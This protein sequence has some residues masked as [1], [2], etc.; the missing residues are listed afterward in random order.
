MMGFA[1]SQ[2]LLSAPYMKHRGMKIQVL[3]SFWPGGPAAEKDELFWVRVIDADDKYKVIPNGPCRTSDRAGPGPFLARP[4]V[5]GLA[6]RPRP[7]P[8]R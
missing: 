5:A 1:T 3:G 2:W 4:G 7:G 8:A 6:A